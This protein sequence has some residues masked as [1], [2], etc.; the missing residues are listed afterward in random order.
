MLLDRL[1]PKSILITGA[2]KRLGSEIARKLAHE[3]WNIVAHYHT[4]RSDAAML[5]RELESKY[6]ITVDLIEANLVSE[7]EVFLLIEQASDIAEGHLFGLINNA[8]IFEY[9]TLETME[10]SFFDNMINVNYKAPLFLTK[11]FADFL[12][13]RPGCVIH[14]LDQKVFNLNVDYLSY[15]FSKQAL[16]ES[17]KLLAKA[18]APR[19]IRVC[20]VAPG[21]S[22]PSGGQSKEAFQRSH[23]KTPLGYGSSPADIAET[24]C[25]LLNSKSITGETILV[26][27]GQHMLSIDRDVMFLT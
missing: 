5:K 7:K 16:Y 9:D 15:T 23:V 2:G 21:L 8:S 19:K 1:E 18:L 13:N 26:D 24:I 22:L 11:Y 25:F 6:Q 14:L 27:A 17:I 10:S 20:G 4:S 12:E 3:G